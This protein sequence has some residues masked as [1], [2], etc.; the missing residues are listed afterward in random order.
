MKY[1]R[2]DVRRKKRGATITL[3]FFI[4]FLCLLIALS[5]YARY[6]F[7]GYNNGSEKSGKTSSGENTPGKTAENKTVDFM[8]LQ[9]GIF[10]DAN[11]LNSQKKLLEPY[12]NVFTVDSAEGTRVYM[13]IFNDSKKSDELSKTLTEKQ[14]NNIQATYGINKNDVCDAEIAEILIA[15]IQIIDK[16]SQ[17]DVKSYKTQDLKKW[18]AALQNV[19]SKSKNYKS[20]TECKKFISIM[21]D[22]INKEYITKIYVFMLNQLKSVGVKLD[23]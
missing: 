18:C 7:K 5:I 4:L 22:E 12:G 2:Y 15:D 6:F 19:D 11:N 23:K 9:C 14:I 10:K 21:P 16:L 8:I 17:K 1:T 20:L 3:I 13:G